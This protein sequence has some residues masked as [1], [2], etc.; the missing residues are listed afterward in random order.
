MTSSIIIFFLI[1]IFIFSN[2]YERNYFLKLK[3]NE[4]HYR[5]KL[6]NIQFAYIELYKAI[7]KVLKDIDYSE[8]SYLFDK[9]HSHFFGHRRFVYL[10]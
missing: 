9:Y 8:Y 6:E 7:L 5:T 10:P 2:I 3:I 1:I 4:Q